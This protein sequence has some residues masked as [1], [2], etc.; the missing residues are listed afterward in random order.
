MIIN[1][2]GGGGGGDSGLK[3]VGGIT[4]PSNP[5]ENMV[6]VITDID[7]ES[8]VCSFNKPMEPVDGMVWV[9]GP[10]SFSTEVN[11]SEKKPTCVYIRKCYQYRFDTEKDR[12]DF[13]EIEGKIYRDGDWRT[14]DNYSLC[15]FGVDQQQTTGGFISVGKQAASN[16]NTA[17]REPDV[18][19]EEGAIIVSNSAELISDVSGAGIFHTKEAMDLTDFKTIVI[20]GEFYRGGNTER[21]LALLT[22]TRLTD[23]YYYDLSST[24][25]P[26]VKN[27]ST[28]STTVSL[29]V[30]SVN[31]KCYIGI[32]LTASWVKI[33]NMYLVPKDVTV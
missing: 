16:S 10:L 18:K 14:L 28:G 27:I 6:W 24:I 5:K 23:T 3:V 30:T 4:E 17:K 31:T 26:A 33:T 13:I 11:L 8:V 1:M 32:G 12:Y 20:E 25:R 9:S 22:W 19:F 7:V 15:V 2:I 21:N 29:D